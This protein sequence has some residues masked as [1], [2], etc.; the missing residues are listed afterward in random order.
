MEN[1]DLH[2]IPSFFNEEVVEISF[3][4]NSKFRA[5]ITKRKEGTFCVRREK[6]DLSEWEFIGKG[7]WNPNEPGTT[8]T[9]RI[10]TARTLAREKL[11]STT[12]GIDL[13]ANPST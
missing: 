3:S 11:L 4:Q 8:L 12:D 6:W 5:I 7:F 13:N 9:D 2:S 10:E 1:P